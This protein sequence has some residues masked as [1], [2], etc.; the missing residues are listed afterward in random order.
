MKEHCVL[1]TNSNFPIVRPY[2][3]HENKKF[4]VFEAQDILSTVGLIKTVQAKAAGRG[5]Y[6]F[7]EE[8]K[9]KVIRPFEPFEKNIGLTAGKVSNL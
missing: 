4:V 9:Y 7:E 6:T 3:P 1:D 5:N 2:L 8:T